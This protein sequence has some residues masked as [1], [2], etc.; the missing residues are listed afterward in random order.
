MTACSA[1]A[2]GKKGV[3]GARPL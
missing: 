2:T 3:M 1:D